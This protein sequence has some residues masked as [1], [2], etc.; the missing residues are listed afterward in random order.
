MYRGQWRLARSIRNEALGREIERKL[1][2]RKESAAMLL[3]LLPVVIERA[4]LGCF[5]S[6]SDGCE[7][8]RQDHVVR[9][10]GFFFHSP[11]CVLVRL[12]VAVVVVVVVVVSTVR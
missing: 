10:C 9:I 8:T 12:F 7:R 5:L 4:E 6:P 3:L 2:G 11:V 1:K